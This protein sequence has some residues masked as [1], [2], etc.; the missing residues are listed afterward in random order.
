MSP[1]LEKKLHETYPGIFP[2][3][4]KPEEYATGWS[5]ETDDGWYAIIDAMCHTMANLHTTRMQI[6]E[7]LAK[8]LD[9][10]PHNQREGATPE[11]FLV[12]QPPKVIARQVKEKFGTLR[13][14]YQLEFEPRFQEQAYGDHSF[15]EARLIAYRYNSY[16]DGI[17]YLAE[18][19]SSRTCEITGIEGELHGCN[20]GKGWKK[21]LNR[22]FAK[23]DAFYSSRNYLPLADLPPSEKTRFRM[24]IR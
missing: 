14:Y 3:P 12:V 22:E 6:S 1:K 2:T 21:T 10:A 16:V 9:I 18:V 23:A 5:I 20:E 11:Y 7:S 24:R 17:V 15:P 13:F 4:D 19:F 8:A